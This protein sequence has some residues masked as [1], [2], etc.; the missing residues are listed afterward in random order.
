MG[1]MR[2]LLAGLV[3]LAG[4]LANVSSTE[5]VSAQQL[6]TDR[7]L[8]VIGDSVMVG[9]QGTIVS[10]LPGWQVTVEAQVG[11]SLLGAASIVRA[12]RAEIGEIAVIELGAN[13]GLDPAV[14]RQRV[15][16]MMDAL[17]GVPL[18]I[19]INQ[20]SFEGG[21]NALN[22]A[23]AAAAAAYPNLEVVDW[24]SMV[25]ARP[26]FVGGDGLHLSSAGRQA[27]AGAIS[28][29]LFVWV[30]ENTRP[31]PSI[32]EVVG[33]YLAS[34]IAGIATATRDENVF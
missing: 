32:F 18:V 8:F 9:A 1:P 27:M 5:S 10:S 21:R 20:A 13:D 29:H 25:A 2:R 3:V 28:A 19:W 7:R 17:A 22:A 30:V 26:D 12:R 6:G 34:A 14:F 23:L 15:D 31:P 24:S 11:L 33:P 16:A 4:V